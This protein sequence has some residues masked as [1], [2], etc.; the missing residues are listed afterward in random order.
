MS[1]SSRRTGSSGRPKGVAL[2]PEPA[3]GEQECPPCAICG[4]RG[5][6]D[7]VAHYLTRGLVV[8]LCHA[9]RTTAFLARCSGR[10]FTERLSAVWAASGVLTVRRQEALEA[11]LHAV[12]Q[13]T[14]GSQK[15]GSYSWPQLRREAERRFAAGEPPALVIT[16]LRQNH[17]DGPAMVPSIRTMRRW[18][19]QAR[20]LET[21]SNNHRSNSRVPGPDGRSS[22]LWKPFVDL[23]STGVAYPTQSHPR[24][25]PRSP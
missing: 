6:S 14:I 18:F 21:T 15:P 22:S 4:H 20:W 2:A 23:R 19:T 25:V 1:R 16:E 9:H 11:H 13:A 8:W 10:E 17:R 5:R 7:R 3:P 12:Q 24:P